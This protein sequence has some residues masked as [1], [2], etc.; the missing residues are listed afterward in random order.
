LTISSRDM[1]EWRYSATIFDLGTRWRWVESFKLLPLYLWR[2]HPWYLF[3]RRLGGFQ[4][5][6]WMLWRREKSYIAGNRTRP[7]RPVTHHC[8]SFLITSEIYVTTF[9]IQVYGNYFYFSSSQMFVFASCLDYLWQFTYSLLLYSN[10]H[11]PIQ[12]SKVLIHCSVMLWLIT[13][14]FFSTRTPTILFLIHLFC[15]S[16]ENI[17]T[18]HFP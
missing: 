13:V 12:F 2:K 4:S 11:W 17:C 14:S 18:I 6:V 9:Y 5:P 15:G 8:T 3:D 10:S 1:G 16:T 7:L